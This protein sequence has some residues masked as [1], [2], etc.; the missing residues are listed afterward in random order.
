[1]PLATSAS[2]SAPHRFVQVFK[3]GWVAPTFDTFVAHFLPW[4]HPEVRGTM[5]LEPIALGHEGF[6]EQFRRVF[7]LFPDLRGT[8]KRATV[9]GD[10]V[11]IDVEL[12][13]TLGGRPLRWTASDRFAFVDGKV[14][15]RITSFNPL[16]VLLAVVTR[17]SAWGAWWRSGV[18]PP[19]RRVRG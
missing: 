12:T 13:A 18:G 8:V 15:S 3:D 11:V 6:R 9:D 5:P 1:M 10:V 7:A 4:M 17:P 14:K 16:P 19:A 2:A